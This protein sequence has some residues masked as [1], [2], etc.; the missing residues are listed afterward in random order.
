MGSSALPEAHLAR[1]EQRGPHEHGPV[2]E[3]LGVSWNTA[4]VAA[5]AESKR[6]LID[7]PGS[8]TSRGNDCGTCAHESAPSTLK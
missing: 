8:T 6:V 2:A 4:N 7:D 1:S 3:G 5:L